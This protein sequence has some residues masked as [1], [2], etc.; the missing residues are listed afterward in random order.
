MYHL[1]DKLFV[2]YGNF[3]RLH[4]KF[5]EYLSSIGWKKNLFLVARGDYNGWSVVPDYQYD[6]LKK[7]LDSVI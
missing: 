5:H 2:V 4:P 6:S 1:P 3:I 7:H